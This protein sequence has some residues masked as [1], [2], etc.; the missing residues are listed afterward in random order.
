MSSSLGMGAVLLLFS[1]VLS[2]SSSYLGPGHGFV[3][4]FSH[5]TAGG[6]FSSQEEALNK[7]PDNPDA[8][9]FSILDQLEDYRDHEG[10]LHFKLCYPELTGVGGC[11]C[12]EWTQTSNPV[13]SQNIEGFNAISIAFPQDGK[14][15]SWAGLGRS[16]V[17]HRSFLDDTPSDYTWWTS[18]GATEYLYE[19]DVIAYIYLEERDLIGNISHGI[20]SYGIPGPI[21]H[22]VSKVELFLSGETFFHHTRTSLPNNISVPVSVAAVHLMDKLQSSSLSTELDEKTI[23]KFTDLSVKDKKAVFLLVDLP[24]AQEKLV[25]VVPSYELDQERFNIYSVIVLYL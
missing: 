2:S 19:K 5:D 11:H 6:L 17:G 13:I 7:N 18:I 25:T 9:L 1:V 21:P 15:N 12:N 3:K 23:R 14:R 22:L 10:I 8:E 4:V 16:P 20:L 24:S